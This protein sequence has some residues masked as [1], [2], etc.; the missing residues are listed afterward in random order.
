MKN[1][2]TRMEYVVQYESDGMEKKNDPMGL[3]HKIMQGIDL[4]ASF[5]TKNWYDSRTTYAVRGNICSM[6]LEKE[7]A[8]AN[9]YWLHNFVRSH[10]KT[11]L[12][13]MQHMAFPNHLK[14]GT[15]ICEKSMKKGSCENA[16]NNH[17]KI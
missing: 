6:L 15:Q 5:H 7:R 12:I 16:S 4:Q 2:K 13:M 17:G 14:N 11:V 1:D 3:V 9:I 8:N 10:I